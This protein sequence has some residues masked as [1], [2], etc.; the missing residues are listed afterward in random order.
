MDPRACTGGGL[1]DDERAVLAH[2]LD[3]GFGCVDTSSIGRL[4]D[5]VASL[6][7]LCQVC[8]YEGRAAMIL[9]SAADD[10]VGGRSYEFSF[11]AGQDSDEV[12]I[13]PRPVIGAIVADLRQGTAV[14]QIAARFHSALSDAMVAIA[15]RARDA[16]LDGADL[17]TVV[18]AGGVFQNARLLGE[19]ATAL[20]ARGFEVLIPRQVPLNDGRHRAGPDTCRRSRNDGR[21]HVTRLRTPMERRQPC[22]WQSQAGWWE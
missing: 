19:S 5:A 6:V 9:E 14:S 17:N 10:G 15:V 20:R 12:T 18:L 21:H 7:G 13:D 8:D 11:A 3:T 22:A 2:Q 16:H 1:P 4:F